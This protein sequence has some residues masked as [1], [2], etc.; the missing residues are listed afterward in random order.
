MRTCT[1]IHTYILV[2]CVCSAYTMQLILQ[3]KHHVTKGLSPDDKQKFTFTDIGKAAGGVI[4]KWSV[5][6]SVILCNIGVCA[7]Y[8]VFIASNIQVGKEVYGRATPIDN[9][10][11][12]SF[13]YVCTVCLFVDVL[14]VTSSFPVCPLSTPLMSH[15]FFFPLL[16][17]STSI[18][19]LPPLLSSPSLTPPPSPLPS[20]GPSAVYL[21]MCK[22]LSTR[23]TC[24]YTMCTRPSFPYSFYSPSSHPSS[25]LHMRPTSEWCSWL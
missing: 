7:G 9:C 6:F 13:A 10:T 2:F 20:S 22:A 11:Y 25:T 14:V 18:T 19:I 21:H 15:Y 24:P 5:D 23:S 16:S 1:C 17:S 12:H 8:T 4:G 3:C